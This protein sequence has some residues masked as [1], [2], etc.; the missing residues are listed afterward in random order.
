MVHGIAAFVILVAIVASAAGAVV[1]YFWPHAEG[2]S[3]RL[4]FFSIP[5]LM[6]L[7][8]FAIRCALKTLLPL[9]PDAKAPK[10]T[11]FNGIKEPKTMQRIAVI[12]FLYS[13]FTFVPGFVIESRTAAKAA[14]PRLWSPEPETRLSTEFTRQGFLYVFSTPRPH[15][16]ILVDLYNPQGLIIGTFGI[17]NPEG[18]HQLSGSAKLPRRV[19]LDSET[20]KITRIPRYAATQCGDGWFSSSTGRGTCSHHGGVSRNLNQYFR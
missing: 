19:Q 3:S 16:R 7:G 18:K 4:L 5:S 13:C 6:V 10:T 11:K 12:L 9:S 14:I 20:V 8:V 1:D 2:V 17:A 15:S